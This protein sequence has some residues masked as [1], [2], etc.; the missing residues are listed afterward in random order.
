M[1]QFWYEHLPDD[2][3]RVCLSL[4]GVTACTHVSSMH[5]IEEKRPRLREACLR[6]SY[7]SYETKTPPL[8]T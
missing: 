7:N 2:M 1:E 5:L 4:N 8:Q 6:K 3:Y